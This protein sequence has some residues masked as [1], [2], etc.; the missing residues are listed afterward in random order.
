MLTGQKPDLFDRDLLHR[1]R[2][3]FLHRLSTADFLLQR[4]AAELDER[5]DLV[6]RDFPVVLDLGSG[7]GAMVARLLRRDNVARVIASDASPALMRALS[8]VSKVVCDEEFLPFGEASFHLVTSILSLHFIN[9]LPDTLSQI[10]QTLRPDGLFMA[11]VP[12]GRTLYELREAFMQAEEEI[13]GGASPRIAPMAGVREYGSLL[14]RAGFALPVVDIDCVK[15]RYSDPLALMREL[16]L[17]G[18]GNVM[19]ARLK[20]PMSR[21]LLQRV[22]EIYRREHGEEEGGIS[23]TFEIIYMSGWCPDESQPQPLAPG[24]AKAP[25]SSVLGNCPLPEK[26]P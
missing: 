26:K 25:L 6:L 21:S 3:R 18:A 5:L 19:S 11:A 10:R 17:M 22:M 12:G 16:R 20:N 2:E 23:V 9:D 8:G 4:A 14:Q 24:S 7:N 13:T 15:V 1:R